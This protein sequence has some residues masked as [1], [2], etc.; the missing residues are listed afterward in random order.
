MSTDPVAMARLRGKMAKEKLALEGLGQ[1][2]EKMDD[3]RRMVLWNGQILTWASPE[4]IG[5]GT[6]EAAR[7]NVDVLRP[8]FE[9]WASSSKPRAMS[10]EAIQP[11]A[12]RREWRCLQI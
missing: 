1:E 5:I 9:R 2:W 11:Q 4:V 7:A 8:L 6:Y 12:P 3:I 10:V